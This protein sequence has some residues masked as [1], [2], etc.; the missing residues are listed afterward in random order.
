MAKESAFSRKVQKHLKSRGAWVVK[1]HASA[2][3]PKGI[4]DLLVCFCGV[5]IGLELK[6]GSKLSEWQELQG[7]RILKAGGY[8][9]ELRAAD[10]PDKLDTLLDRIEHEGGYR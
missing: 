3:T 1:F 5:F 10:F 6:T 4:P 8:W 7:R 2:Y 9:L